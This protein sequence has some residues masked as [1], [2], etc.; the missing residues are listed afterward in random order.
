MDGPVKVSNTTV[1]LQLSA[2]QT[3]RFG[4][5]MRLNYKRD[6]YMITWLKVRSQVPI[7]MISR[8]DGA[9]SRHARVAISLVLIS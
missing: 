9:K 3:D 7:A 1:W 5:S 4:C 8:S 6:V 2:R